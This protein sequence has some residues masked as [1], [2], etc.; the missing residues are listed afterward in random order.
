MRYQ[1][2]EDEMRARGVNR[3]DIATELGVRPNTVTDWL[4]GKHS[5][6][7]PTAFAIR[8][9]FFDGVSIDYLFETV[10]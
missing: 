9:A 3:N 2:L 5:M 8:D 10:E 4:S 1:N 7:V 6:S